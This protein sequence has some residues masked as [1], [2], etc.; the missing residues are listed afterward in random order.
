MMSQGDKSLHDFMPGTSGA[1][2]DI[3]GR[4]GAPQPEGTGEIS[5][6]AVLEA[7]QAIYDPEIPVNIY[8]LGL[9]Y[10]VERG[11]RGAVAI[12]MT[13]TA[14]NCPVAGEMPQM[15]AD[16]VA[17]VPGAGEVTVRL[18]WDPPWDRE[19]MSELAKLELGFF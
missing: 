15:V 10:A 6:E 18:V 13:L 12:D 9:I 17:Q 14:P 5:E 11:P 19:R 1:D 16:A 8:D 2:E 3:V 4:A 7:L